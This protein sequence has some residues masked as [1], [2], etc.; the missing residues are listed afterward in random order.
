MYVKDPAK[1]GYTNGQRL[2]TGVSIIS[3]KIDRWIKEKQ[4]SHELCNRLV[5]LESA[6]LVLKTNQVTLQSEVLDIRNII[7]ILHAKNRSILAKNSTHDIDYAELR[8]SNAQLMDRMAAMES[9][10]SEMEFG[11]VVNAARLVKIQET[12][13]TNDDVK[14]LESPELKLTFK[15]IWQSC[16]PQ[17]I[18]KLQVATQIRERKL[19]L[20]MRILPWE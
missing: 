10:M 19:I 7:T 3:N 18:V 11:M 16:K 2:I 4:S 9:V 20:L 6:N 15:Q 13:T 14:K 17:R 8:A 1:Q 5:M 12:T